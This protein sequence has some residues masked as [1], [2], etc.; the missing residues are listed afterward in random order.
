MYGGKCAPRLA[1]GLPRCLGRLRG[2]QRLAFT[3]REDVSLLHLPSTLTELVLHAD[4]KG[5]NGQVRRAHF[6]A[7]T[8]AAR[9]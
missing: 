6:R 3:A 8:L 4:C 2:L 1:A 5:C 9:V 7:V